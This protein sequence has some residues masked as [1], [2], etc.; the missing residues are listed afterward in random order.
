MKD[1]LN[2]IVSEAMA[3][4]EKAKQYLA[5]EGKTV[6]ET[7][8]ALGFTEVAYFCRVFKEKTGKTIMEYYLRLKMERAKQLLRENELSVKEIAETLA[9]NEPNYF[10][11]TFKRI[12]GLT[13]TAY[14]KRSTG[15]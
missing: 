2:A 15:L 11:K 1:K 4:L 10:T 7:A 12:T 13:P 14:K 6:R 5:F 8:E 3:Q 9:F